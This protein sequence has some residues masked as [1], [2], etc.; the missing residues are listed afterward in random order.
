MDFVGSAIVGRLQELVPLFPI[1]YP[2]AELI[3]HE[4]TS[5]RIVRMAEE[6]QLD[7]GL[8]HTPNRQES[9]H[10]LAARCP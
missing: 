1:E 4:S 2:G 5:A 6:A 8:V 10:Q 9:P 3:L 7:I